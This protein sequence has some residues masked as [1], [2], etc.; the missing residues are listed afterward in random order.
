[1]K[2]LGDTGVTVGPGS[3]DVLSQDSTLNLSPSSQVRSQ[4]SQPQSQLPLS[5]SE[6]EEMT[7]R[8]EALRVARGGSLYERKQHTSDAKRGTPGPGQYRLDDNHWGNGHGAVAMHAA[9][10]VEAVMSK[11]RQVGMPGSSVTWMRI[12]TAPTIPGRSQGFGYEEGMNGELIMIK[13]ASKR[14]KKQLKQQNI[15]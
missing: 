11:S 10:G 3:Y 9:F 15:V 2:G 12:P 4:R 8:T 1:M 7:A 5:V 14:Y 13:D 6:N